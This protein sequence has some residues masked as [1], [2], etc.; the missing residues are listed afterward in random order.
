MYV[1]LITLVQNVKNDIKIYVL[2]PFCAKVMM[3]CFSQVTTSLDIWVPT[4][5]DRT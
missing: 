2:L 5:A 3:F 4:K 1:Y